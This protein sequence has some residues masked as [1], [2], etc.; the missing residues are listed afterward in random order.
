VW[1]VYI[2]VYF[3]KEGTYEKGSP[4][5]KEVHDTL[6][7]AVMHSCYPSTW[8]AE[9]GGFQS[10][11]GHPKLHRKILVSNKQLHNQRWWQRSN[12]SIK[13]GEHYKLEGSLLY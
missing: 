6:E 2:S 3:S 9:A 1:T 5:I 13:A 8:E 4:L 11:C 10:V 7:T 12:P